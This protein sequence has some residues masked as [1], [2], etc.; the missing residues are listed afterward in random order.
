MKAIFLDRDGV[1]NPLVYDAEHGIIDCPL[2]PDQFE[3]YPPAIEGIRLINQAEIPAV[4]I[5]NQP[6]IAKGKISYPLFRRIDGEMRRQ[7]KA[8]DCFLNDAYYCLHHPEAVNNRFKVECFCRKPKPGLIIRAAAEHG[9]DLSG[10]FFIGDG[11]TDVAAGKE[12]G[13]KTILIGGEKCDHCRKYKELGVKPD[14]IAADLREAAM[15][16]IKEG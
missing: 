6:G 12:A 9:F 14:Y 4:V 1:I 8:A 5:S 3:L 16:A 11:L 2:N 7:L 10:S 15:I 13:C